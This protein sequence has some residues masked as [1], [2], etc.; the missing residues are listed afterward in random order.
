MQLVICD[1]NPQECGQQDAAI[2]SVFIHAKWCRCGWHI[3]DRGWNNHI[4]HNLGGRNH[5]N[6]QEIDNLVRLTKNWL[7]SMM[8]DVETV[9]EYQ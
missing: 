8:K 2:R 6:C 7:Y 9:E 1:G 3:V 5:K 4:G